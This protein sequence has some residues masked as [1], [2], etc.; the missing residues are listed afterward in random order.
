MATFPKDD[1][2]AEYVFDRD[3]SQTQSEDVE[4]PFRREVATDFKTLEDREKFAKMYDEDRESELALANQ[5]MKDQ[6]DKWNAMLDE[7]RGVKRRKEVE[8]YVG[9]EVGNDKKSR[10]PASDDML[11]IDNLRKKYPNITEAYSDEELKKISPKYE[12]S[13]EKLKDFLDPK[14]IKDESGELAKP[15]MSEEEFMKQDAIKKMNQEAV[16]AANKRLQAANAPKD[17]KKELSYR[18]LLEQARKD[19]KEGYQKD[20]DAQLYATIA[21]ALG[22]IGA[23][24]GAARAGVKADLASGFDYKPSTK[25]AQEAKDSYQRLLKEYQALNKPKDSLTTYEKEKLKRQDLAQERSDK[26]ERRR[27]EKQRQDEE[28]KK[29]SMLI[30]GVGYA[31]DAKDAKEIRKD[32]TS[33]EDAIEMLNKVKEMGK[34][35]S[36]LDPRDFTKVKKIDSLLNQAVGKMRISLTGGGPLTE[37]ERQMIRSSIGD[38]T[39]LLSTE[40]AERAKLDQLIEQMQNSLRRRYEN[41]GVEMLESPSNKDSG[42]SPAQ[43]RGIEVVMKKNNISRKDAIEALKK[44]GKL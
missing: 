19:L 38:P 24:S 10:M 1:R 36:K 11:N 28:R 33:T 26:A 31:V 41:S 12:G 7:L 30:P 5:G 4:I 27:A 44:A 25:Y 23:A 43:E 35:I 42:Y 15:S 6:T 16:D 39:S 8:N 34:D 20:R 3:E 17:E 22:K 14:Y 32:K 9:S 2:F 40:S 13:K 37:E 29:K 21:N 18:E